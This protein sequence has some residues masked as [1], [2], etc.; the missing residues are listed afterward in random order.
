MRQEQIPQQTNPNHR[1]ATETTGAFKLPDWIDM[2]GDH[3]VRGHVGGS[4]L[5]TVRLCFRANSEGR[6]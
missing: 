5:P 1:N 6:G 2:R 4:V 3:D